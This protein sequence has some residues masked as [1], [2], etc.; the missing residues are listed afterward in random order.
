M[1]VM[2]LGE[3]EPEWKVSTRGRGSGRGRGRCM[4]MSE[5]RTGRGRSLGY[6]KGDTLTERFERD[7]IAVAPG[8]RGR[9]RGEGA[10]GSGSRC[11]RGGRVGMWVH[12]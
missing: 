9:G 2:F 7:A 1:Q 10:R 8:Q 11:G 4:I 5:G 6:V 3:R 12:V